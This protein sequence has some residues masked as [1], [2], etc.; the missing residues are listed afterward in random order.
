MSDLRLRIL[1]VVV[2]VTALVAGLLG[3]WAF[4][5]WASG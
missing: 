2:H 3:G 4:F 5:D 1:M